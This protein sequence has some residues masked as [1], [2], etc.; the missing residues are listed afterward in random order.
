LA[1]ASKADEE[2][3]GQVASMFRAIA[4]GEEIHA[5]NLAAV[6]APAKEAEKAMTTNVIPMSTR[7]NL[8]SAVAHQILER[9]VQYPRLL[10]QAQEKKDKAVVRALRENLAA[11]PLHLAWYRQ[12]LQ[13][14]DG[15]KG[16]NVDFYVCSRCGASVRAVKGSKCEVCGAPKEKFEKVR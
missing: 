15:Y 3:Y 5:N 8:E 14:L 16:G 2:G 6:I 13:D 7:E 11:E 1:Y 12:A 9:D 10:E 4:R